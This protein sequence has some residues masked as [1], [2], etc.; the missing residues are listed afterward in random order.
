M[1]SPYTLGIMG[2]CLSAVP[3]V[4]VIPSNLQWLGH[5]TICLPSVPLP[6]SRGVVHT[7][8]CHVGLLVQKSLSIWRSFLVTSFVLGG[9]ALNRHKAM[10]RQP[11]TSQ[12]RPTGPQLFATSIRH[13]RVRLHA[14]MCMCV[15]VCVCVCAR[16]CAHARAR[17]CLCMRRHMSV[18]DCARGGA[19]MWLVN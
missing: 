6:D 18:R 3:V 1:C 15:C 11:S 19:P 7:K 13:M 2:V 8:W 5:P 4:Y 17:A 10:Q 12:A 16:V 9:E 14:C